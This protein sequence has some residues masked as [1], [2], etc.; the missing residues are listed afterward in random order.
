MKKAKPK[1]IM[2]VTRKDG[3]VRAKVTRV[4]EKKPKTVG[5][6]VKVRTAKETKRSPAEAVIHAA[7]EYDH[8]RVD[9]RAVKRAIA[10]YDRAT[11]DE[12]KP[13]KPKKPEKP[14]PLKLPHAKKYDFAWVE[15]LSDGSVA[16]M[17]TRFWLPAEARSLAEWLIAFA[18]WAE[19]RE[20]KP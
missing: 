19:S 4:K 5:E 14:A 7:R 15:K 8:C 3:R 1:Y 20:E 11:A 17:Q 16:S 13:K 12:A 6:I 10:A 2:T 9:W 18:A